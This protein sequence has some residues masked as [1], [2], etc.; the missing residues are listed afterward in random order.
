MNTGA[1]RH[2]EKNNVFSGPLMSFQKCDWSVDGP[3]IGVSELTDIC[4]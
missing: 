3:Q 2:Y 1:A 4:L